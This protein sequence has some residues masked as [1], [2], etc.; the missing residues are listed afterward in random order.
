MIRKYAVEF[1]VPG[2]LTQDLDIRFNVPDNCQLLHISGVTSNDAAT[3]IDVGDETNA[4]LH[5][6]DMDIGSGANEVHELAN[7]QMYSEFELGQWPRIADGDTVV[8]TVDWDGDSS[9]DA[10]QNTTLVL[11]FAEG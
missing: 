11:T 2:T 1:H 6:N 9:G 7:V 5:V 3:T 8:I 4:A 10:G